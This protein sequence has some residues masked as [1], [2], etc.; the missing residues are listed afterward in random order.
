MEKLKELLKTDGQNAQEFVTDSLAR[1]FV[2]FSDGVV[3]NE[4]HREFE[5]IEIFMIV[6]RRGIK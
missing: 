5:K 1:A 6:K 2:D 4:Y 3:E